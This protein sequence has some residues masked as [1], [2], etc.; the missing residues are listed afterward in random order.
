M[1]GVTR[2]WRIA[3]LGCIAALAGCITAGPPGERPPSVGGTLAL[4]GP[5]FGPQTLGASEFRS[6]ERELFLGADFSGA[7]GSPLIARLA[8]DP[9][10]G[11]G[12]RIFR[13]SEP[14][15]TA[16][17][18]RR[19]DCSVFHFSLERTGWR[20]NDIYALRVSLELSCSL[21]SGDTVQGSLT[22]A[23]CY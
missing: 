23:S 18:L 17:L 1:R 8:V 6:G 10:S 14:F 3:L 12:V 2:V 13:T 20:I 21:P 15:A 19:S 22:A 9:L 11:P 16:L 5:T 7:V 4:S